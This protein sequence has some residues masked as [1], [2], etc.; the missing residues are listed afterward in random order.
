M[1]GFLYYNGAILCSGKYRALSQSFGER[2]HWEHR[3]VDTKVQAHPTDDIVK[4]PLFEGDLNLRDGN[5]IA[6]WLM[7]NF[8]IYKWT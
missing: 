8:W 5:V 3:M 1:A 7:E 4:N 6:L 2:E